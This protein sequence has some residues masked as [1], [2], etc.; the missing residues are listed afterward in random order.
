MRALLAERPA[1]KVFAPD[2]AFAPFRRAR[3]GETRLSLIRP[4]VPGSLIAAMMLVP[5]GV[6]PPAAAVVWIEPSAKI[7][8]LPAPLT[9]TFPRTS[10]LLEGDC[11]P[12][13]RLPAKKEW[14]LE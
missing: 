4:A 10:S 8:P 14:A 9:F 3:F 13:P 6:P 2:Q 7:R 12:I 5:D 11:V 1:P